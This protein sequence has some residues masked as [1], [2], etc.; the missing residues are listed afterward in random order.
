VPDHFAVFAERL[1]TPWT[2]EQKRRMSVM[3]TGGREIE[4]G[5][6]GLVL[7][8]G[9]RLVEVVQCRLRRMPRCSLY[10]G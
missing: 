3:G 8:Y 1:F 10:V 9:T 4:I 5:K 7:S 6:P 2:L